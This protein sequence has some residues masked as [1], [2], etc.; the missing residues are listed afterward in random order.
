MYDSMFSRALT[1][2]LKLVITLFARLI[3]KNLNICTKNQSELLYRE[4]YESCHV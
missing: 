2:K 4:I 3:R 1:C